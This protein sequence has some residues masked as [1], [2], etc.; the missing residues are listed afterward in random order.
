MHTWPTSLP[1]TVDRGKT[2]SK[3]RPTLEVTILLTFVAACSMAAM[4]LVLTLFL[5]RPAPP[6][7]TLPQKCEVVTVPGLVNRRVFVCPVEQNEQH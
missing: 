7:V 2:M 5:P 6:S 3:R 1:S 4:Y